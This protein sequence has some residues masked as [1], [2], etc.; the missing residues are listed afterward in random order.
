MELDKAIKSCKDLKK[1]SDKKPDW[2]DIIE[3]I[4]KARY[5]SM[6]GNNYSLKFILIDN[7]EKIQKIAEYCQQQFISQAHYVVIVCS[8]PIRTIN[9]Y[10]EKGKTYCTQ[11]AGAGIQNFLLKLG[12]IELSTYWVRHFVEKQIKRELKI[13]DN[14]IVEAVFPIGYETKVKGMKKKTNFKNRT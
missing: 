2:R 6:A 11:Q 10:K 5:A 9:L 14:I 13:P 1:F 7:R 8:D 12:E 4:D 3:A